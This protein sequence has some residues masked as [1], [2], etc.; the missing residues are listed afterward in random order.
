[1]TTTADQKG[2]IRQLSLEHAP[3]ETSELGVKSKWANM[4]APAVQAPP[5]V[6]KARPSRREP[7]PA[8]DWTG[9]DSA[10]QAQRQRVSV[11]HE[12]SQ[13][14]RL[15]WGQMG[16][17]ERSPK[18]LTRIPSGR[19]ANDCGRARRQCR[20]S[21]VRG[22]GVPEPMG[23]LHSTGRQAE[24]GDGAAGGATAM[25]RPDPQNH[26]GHR[27][28]VSC[29]V[30]SAERSGSSSH[31]TVFGSQWTICL[32]ALQGKARELWAGTPAGHRL[33]ERATGGRQRGR[34]TSWIVDCEL[35]TRE[36][37]TQKKLEGEI[38]RNCCRVE[39]RGG[40]VDVAWP[41]STRGRHRRHR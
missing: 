27:K 37:K 7:S 33:T 41:G 22:I 6:G 23:E 4:P 3:M 20:V 36:E 19:G 30:R 10:S 31:A 34:R 13:R 2:Q 16:R 40:R 9:L 5:A 24:F 28:L 15:M 32:I 26:C 39:R 25:W 12:R 17:I 21:A 14:P 18:R 29:A 35:K 1:M 11:I 8:L 38:A